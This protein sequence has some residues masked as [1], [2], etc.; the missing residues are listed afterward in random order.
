MGTFKRQALA[1]NQSMASI[2]IWFRSDGAMMH[3]S[4]K[5]LFL[6]EV[7]AMAA[8]T[9]RK[10]E[11]S[12]AVHTVETE[13]ILIAGL[14]ENVSHC[15]VEHI[16]PLEPSVTRAFWG[17]LGELLKLHYHVVHHFVRFVATPAEDMIIGPVMESDLE[18][19]RYT[20]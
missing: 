13:D 19:I 9:L 7:S 12:I 11:A 18:R 10:P 16:G 17:R 6:R 15:T 4:A 3:P 2:K 5:A 1:S 20:Y 8:K 14:S